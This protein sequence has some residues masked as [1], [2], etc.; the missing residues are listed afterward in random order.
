MVLAQLIDE[1][2]REQDEQWIMQIVNEMRADRS[3]IRKVK[4]F[5]RATSMW[6]PTKTLHRNIRKLA[7]VP[8]KFL[9]SVINPMMLKVRKAAGQHTNCNACTQY[10]SLLKT[11]RGP[12]ARAHVLS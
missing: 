1:Q 9:K 4:A 2:E 12:K 10:T 5:W 8:V 6:R 3:K 7:K 11:T